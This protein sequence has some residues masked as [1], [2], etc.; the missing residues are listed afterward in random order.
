MA[1]LGS[2]DRRPRQ[3]ADK[4]ARLIKEHGIF[5]SADVA[6]RREHWLAAAAV[7]VSGAIFCVAA[8]FAATP[9]REVPAFI[10]AYESPLVL[11]D[12]ITSVLLFGQF[13]ILRSRALF[14][15]ACGYL[16]TAFVAI[17][18]ELSFPGVFTSAGLFGGGLQ[19]TIWLY[20]S[21]HS[22]FPLCVLL[23]ALFKHIESGTAMSATSYRASG[24]IITAGA[25]SVLAFAS[26]L[27]LT[28][29]ANRN[30]LPALIHGTSFTPLMRISVASLCALCVA[31]LVALWRQP[32]RTA[33]DLW[34]IV[35]MFA[36][37]FDTSLC[38]I[39][40]SGR[41]DLGWYGGRIYG[42]LAASSLLII[43]LG[44]SASHYGKL[45]R[46]SRE[47]GAANK[48]L[49]RLSLVDG[50]TNIANRRHF[51]THLAAQLALGRRRRQAIALI[52]CDVDSFKAYNDSYGHQAGDECLKKIASVLQACCRRPGDLAARYGGEE[53]AMILPDTG[54]AAARRIAEDARAAVARLGILHEH[55]RAAFHVSI[56]GGIAFIHGSSDTSA[57]QLIHL[58]DQALY[59]AKSDGR[60][61]MVDAFSEPAPLYAQSS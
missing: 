52:L 17:T 27:A 2:F 1:G 30:S 8:P 44:E 59:R 19:T 41:F 48:S 31:A 22:G 10:P 55:S 29:I 13:N 5:L 3:R 20:V 51:D 61:R 56:S 25:A 12:L 7:L 6:S 37:L 36:W 15:L 40:N 50:L 35:V 9:L 46:L 32:Q 18:H 33:L 28:I 14:A 53:F 45:A 57:G 23:Y 54:L 47:L 21:W 34:L 42:L 11:S 16:F 60:N 26:L 49:E 4:Q 58:A 43:L 38:G 39:F 24:V